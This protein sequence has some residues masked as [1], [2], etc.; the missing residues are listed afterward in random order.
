MTTQQP[1]IEGKSSHYPWARA[2]MMVVLYG[3][4]LVFLW[5]FPTPGGR[6]FFQNLF[7]GFLYVLAGLALVIVTIVFLLF[8]PLPLPKTLSDEGKGDEEEEESYETDDVM[9]EV[10]SARSLSVPSFKNVG[11]ESKV[12]DIL[13]DLQDDLEPKCLIVADPAAGIIAVT[14]DDDI[15][16]ERILRALRL[17]LK[18]AGIA[19]R[20]LR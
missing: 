5:H 1:D 14:D 8:L 15:E 13:Y 9:G 11:V 2:L 20:S 16:A 3:A 6:I 17:R 4:L 18:N 12:W 10:F 19:V 7:R